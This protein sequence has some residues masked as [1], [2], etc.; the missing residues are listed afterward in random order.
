MVAR[1]L[2]G[3]V[4]CV[5]A[6]LVA[7]PAWAGP[8]A[9]ND[10]EYASL[11][12]VFPE[13]EDS[14]TYTLYTTEFQP[15]IRYLEQRYP[16]RLAVSVYGQSVEG[17]N[18]YAV[19]LT[20]ERSR[21]P[22]QRRKKV[23]IDVSI[24]GGERAPL[25]GTVRF[26][27]DMASTGDPD[28][29]ALLDTTVLV[30]TFPNPDGWIRR[31]ETQ[32]PFGLRAGTRTNANGFDLNRQ[33]PSIGYVRSAWG[34]MTQPEVIATKDLYESRY[35]D[36]TWGHSV[37]C[38]TLF[39]TAYVQLLWQAAEN[40]LAENLETFDFSEQLVT[41]ITAATRGLEFS[42]TD[43]QPVMHGTSWETRRRANTG[44]AGGFLT[45][46]RPAGMDLLGLTLEHLGCENNNW[47]PAVLRF[48]VAAVRAELREVLVAANRRQPRVRVD[49]PGV[50]GYLDDD[51]VVTDADANGAGYE[52]AD[53]FEASFP[54]FPYR[55]TR[56]RFFRDLHRYAPRLL[57]VQP[58]S[59]AVPGRLR[60]LDALVITEHDAGVDPRRLETFVRGG[61]TLVLTD[62]AVRTLA[63]VTGVPADAIVRQTSDPGTDL[64]HMDAD[65]R[66]F[67]HPLLAGLNRPEIY[68]EQLYEP[69]PVGF[70]LDDGAPPW[71]AVDQD[72]FEAAGGRVAALD[73]RGT[74]MLGDVAMGA[75]RVVVIGG[76][77][78]QPSEDDFHPYGLAD[79]SVTST[80]YQ[81][82]LNALGA[83]LTRHD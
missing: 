45:Q 31:M 48:G 61:G 49:L 4:G 68:A 44:Y 10:Q 81:V 33:W 66:D 16:D 28:A 2:T 29:L 79:Y 78:P 14:T 25:E 54:Q 21:V 24:H 55:A 50:V 67:T 62:G 37:H 8:V 52:P 82:L 35:A 6:L 75:G 9:T 58:N 1:A 17:R 57:G 71:W 43:R 41:R 73:Q 20:N 38:F 46:P 18:L 22:Y 51:A 5:A 74:V 63:K 83:T 70:S 76:L 47:N 77:L 39:P 40:D 53:A 60:G 36:A 23:V 19:E 30:F 3:A 11:G 69:V 72:A 56:M 26:L 80:G 27:E 64:P 42:G 59:V 15:A 65:S 7:A 13:I 32:M 34:T 12:R